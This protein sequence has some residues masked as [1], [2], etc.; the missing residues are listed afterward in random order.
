MRARLPCSLAVY[1]STQGMQ[2]GQYLAVG[3]A[4]KSKSLLS[5]VNLIFYIFLSFPTTT[6]LPK[7]SQQGPRTVVATPSLNLVYN[8][9]AIKSQSLEKDCFGSQTMKLTLNNFCRKGTSVRVN[10]PQW[11]KKPTTYIELLLCLW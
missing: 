2:A 5:V 3:W 1:L 10:E 8:M 7:N 4:T 9:K 6:Q 11:Q